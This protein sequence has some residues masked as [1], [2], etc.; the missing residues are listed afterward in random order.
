MLTEGI[1]LAER[2]FILLN[3][4][5]AM[6]DVEVFVAA[7]GRFMKKCRRLIVGGL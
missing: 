2:G 6:E 5:L 1:Y 4:E 7:T 3:I